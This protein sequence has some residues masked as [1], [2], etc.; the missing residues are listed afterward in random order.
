[1]YSGGWT[2]VVDASKFFY[3]FPVRPEDQRY[4]GIIHPVTGLEYV[5][6][7]LPMGSGSS[8]GLAGRF[9]LAFIRL[10]KE[11]GDVDLILSKEKLETY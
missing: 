6:V 1:M 3:Q 8:P 11:Q 10:L 4:F 7:G 2:A 5:Y 9:G